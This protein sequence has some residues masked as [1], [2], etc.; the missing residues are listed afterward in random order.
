[1]NFVMK[2]VEQIME[3]FR[4]TKQRK[5]AVSVIAALVLIVSTIAPAA[6]AFAVEENTASTQ[7]YSE[8]IAEEVEPEEND[9]TV[10]NETGDDLLSVDTEESEADIESEEAGQEESADA[11]ETSDDTA[12]MDDQAIEEAVDETS[13][14]A[15]YSTTARAS[16]AAAGETA[17]ETAPVIEPARL[18]FE[19]EN[20]TVYADFDESAGFPEGVELKVKEITREDDPEIYDQYYQK[21]LEQV[22]DKYDEN[23]GLSFAKFYDISFVHDGREIEPSGEVKVRIEYKKTVETETTKAVEAIHF[24]KEDEEKAEVIDA[25]AEGTEKA[26]EAVEF[27]SDQFS[28]YGIVGTEMLTGDVITADGSAYSISVSYGLEAKIPEGAQLKVSEI[29]EESEGYAEYASD[30]AMAIYGE[31]DSVLP[32]LRLF[33]ISIWSGEREIEPAAPVQV[34]IT[35]KDGSTKERENG[36]EFS[37]VHFTE[38][39]ARLIENDVNSAVTFEA[40]SFSVYAVAYT[41]TVDFFYEDAEYHL[42]GGN[43]LSL[44]GLFSELGIERDAADVVSADFST[45]ELVSVEQKDND[46]NLLSLKPFLSAERLTITFSDDEVIV[47]YVTDASG[48]DKITCKFGGV[49]VTTTSPDSR[50]VLQVSNKEHPEKLVERTLNIRVELE[51]STNPKVKIQVPAGFG[52]ISCSAKDGDSIPEKIEKIKIDDE[53]KDFVLGTNIGPATADTHI[54]GVKEGVT[55]WAD[56][57]IT[58]HTDG[59]STEQDIPIYCGDIEYTL[60]DGQHTLEL[61]VNLRIDYDLLTHNSNNEDM[62]PI[63]ITSSSDAGQTSQELYVR[64]TNI[65]AAYLIRSGTGLKGLQEA[66]IA[67]PTPGEGRS[68]EFGMSADEYNFHTDYLG[69]VSYFEEQTYT[70]TYPKHVYYQDNSLIVKQMGFNEGV[71]ST[72]NEGTKEIARG[73]LWVTITEGANGG[74]TIKVLMK[75]GSFRHTYGELGPIEASFTADMSYYEIGGAFREYKDSQGGIIK[76]SDVYKE[77]D[78]VTGIKPGSEN[79]I[80]KL[81]LSSTMTRNGKEFDL[82]TLNYWRSFKAEGGKQ[83]LITPRNAT[84]RDIN[85]DFNLDDLEY[86]LGGFNV[87]PD[88]DYGNCTWYLSNDTNMHIT[89]LVLHGSNIRDLWIITNKRSIQIPTN[90]LSGSVDDGISLLGSAVNISGDVTNKILPADEYI[91]G[92]LFTNDVSQAGYHTNHEFGG[93]SYWGEFENHQ[94]G[95]VSL[96]MLKDGTTKD[97]LDNALKNGTLEDLVYRGSV[98]NQLTQATDHTTIGWNDTGFGR[99]QTTVVNGDTGET[100]DNYYPYDKLH[101]QSV[102]ESGFYTKSQ[103]ML[104]DPDIVINLPEGLS[105]D[106]TS[107]IAKHETEGGAK[108][109]V[110]LELVGNPTEKDVNGVKW[111][112][113]RFRRNEADAGKL[114]AIERINGPKPK[115]DYMLSVSF[116]AV[117][118][119]NCTHQ[120]L[121]LKDIVM[122]D[123]GMSD[124]G[125]GAVTSGWWDTPVAVDRNNFIGNGSKYTVGAA[126]GDFTLKPLI[127]LNVDLSIRPEDETEFY[128]YNGLQSSIAPVVPGKTADL[129]L[130]YISTSPTEYFDGTV[131]YLPIPKM[132][133][134]YSNYFENIDLQNPSGAESVP[135]AR[136]TFGFTADLKQEV[137]LKSDT[138]KWT[139]YYALDSISSNPDPHTVPEAGIE[140]TWEPVVQNGGNVV[141]KTADELGPGDLASVVMVKFVA[142][143]PIETGKTGQM[144]MKLYIHDV[145]NTDG[146][147]IGDTYDYWRSFEKSVTNSQDLTGN[148]NYTSVVAATPAMETVKGKMFVDLDMDG[149]MNGQDPAYSGRKYKIQ[150]KGISDTNSF[151]SREL[152]LLEDGSFAY[153]GEKGPLYLRFGDYRITVT[154]QDDDFSFANTGFRDKV[155]DESNWFNNIFT[156]GTSGTWEFTV[157]NTGANNTQ[158]FKTHCLGIG[159]KSVVPVELIGLKSLTGRNLAQNEFLFTITEAEGHSGQPMPEERR[160]TVTNAADGSFS[161]GTMSFSKIGKYQYVIKET[162]GNAAGVTYDEHEVPVTVD[163][164]ADD[165]G[166]LSAEVVYDNSRSEYPEDQA[167]TD[168]AKFT[169][170]YTLRPAQINLTGKKTL[171]NRILSKD[172]FSFT[173]SADSN[174]PMPENAQ[175][176][177]GRKVVT[178]T[179]AANGAID[180]GTIVFTK[181]GRYEYEIIELQSVSDPELQEVIEFDTHVAKAIVTVSE[182]TATAS[183][184]VSVYYDNTT[185]AFN[186]D[187]AVIDTAKFTNTAPKALPTLGG[188]GSLG[189]TFG[190]L[191]LIMLPALLYGF[192]KRLRERRNI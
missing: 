187:K 35:L 183:L 103:D 178:A 79:K 100:K 133:M 47:I 117:V 55:K 190:G 159:L 186:A 111:T 102:V 140:D 123:P 109:T 93:V 158:A 72:V 122:W 174:T 121:S 141:W 78:T 34:K 180:F 127:G 167:V 124:G 58:G 137:E 132:G 23:T 40:D 6:S 21:A 172:L 91:V 36:A 43:A 126:G 44:S 154:D 49:D 185:S 27:E 18:V 37:T 116:D 86:W 13:E 165:Q 68:A 92:C 4:K 3:L 166:K 33:D 110:L 53:Y 157:T 17:Q 182:N 28:V 119:P 46:W 168:K 56:Q 2:M 45:P 20:Y 65:R 138:T 108:V 160:R 52:I 191:V 134:D 106:A 81:T 19:A 24:N 30:A 48:L 162:H 152:E 7:A 88:S 135:A 38:T 113:Y 98:D 101:F 32:Y 136:K 62:D 97:D 118:N 148:W 39:G 59:S 164:K 144:L 169:N 71:P 139:T 16:E 153:K 63:I 66:I 70:L 188:P 1:M 67:A 99:T 105:L 170:V 26:V 120:T 60:L 8:E 50:Y 75:N 9:E 129:K 74:G 112:T 84:R 173:L 87:K 147:A 89:N 54:V 80:V 94:E 64:A 61:N 11:G 189:F 177:G 179:N 130:D 163:I 76:N 161:F 29:G 156:E 42:D 82:T 90:G 41:Y 83:V 142:Q 128:Q 57:A 175:S 176:E 69:N 145:D 22:Q 150:L 143:G 171:R 149:K 131:I 114:V 115:S 12:D 107:V 51:N 5:R 96:Y 181:A 155:S 14:D 73:H 95:N 77:G 151:F 146:P 192:V 104:V 31:D 85:Y 25:E 15:A 125:K 184:Q 10:D